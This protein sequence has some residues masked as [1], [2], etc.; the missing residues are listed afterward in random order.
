MQIVKTIILLLGTLFIEP[1]LSQ[2]QQSVNNTCTPTSCVSCV[3]DLE[4]KEDKTTIKEWCLGCQG[5]SMEGTFADKNTTCTGDVPFEKCIQT[6][7]DSVSGTAL[8]A[9]CDFGY[10][11]NSDISGVPK[12]CLQ[13]TS[14]LG[15]NCVLASSTDNQEP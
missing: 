13:L 12:E 4:V 6:R 2:I 3:T 5:T 11:L 10:F 9:L 14:S 15:E 8:C 7:F 1:V